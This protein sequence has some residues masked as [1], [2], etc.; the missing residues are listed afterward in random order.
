MLYG[1]NLVGNTYLSDV[2]L[3]D[4]SSG[5]ISGTPSFL[6]SPWILTQGHLIGPFANLNNSNLSGADLSGADLSNAELS[7]TISGN[8]TGTPI[9]LPTDWKLTQGYLVGPYAN[10][11]GADLSGAD[12]SGANL[13]GANLSGA[14]LSGTWLDFQSKSELEAINTLSNQVVALN[15]EIDNLNVASS[16]EYSLAE[17]SDMRSGSSMIAVPNGMAEVGL[18]L[19][20]STNLTDWV[21]VSNTPVMS[22]PADTPTKFFRYRED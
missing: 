7:G 11:S 8:I 12:L 18:V 21:A 10:L 2:D 19:E 6:P 5:N 16:N 22:V 1:I 3:T 4:V 13:F 15:I 9:A 14:D 17:I 20:T